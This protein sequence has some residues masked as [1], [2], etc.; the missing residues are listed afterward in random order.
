MKMMTI[1]LYVH[2]EDNDD[3]IDFSRNAFDI[4]VDD[5]E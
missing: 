4:V 2:E 1:E 3:D 5:E